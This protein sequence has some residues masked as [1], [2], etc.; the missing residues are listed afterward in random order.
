[1]VV[2]EVALAHHTLQASERRKLP[3]HDHASSPHE[4]QR[5][6]ARAFEASSRAQG[7]VLAVGVRLQHTTSGV[8]G[9][10][11]VCDSADSSSNLGCKKCVHGS[12]AG[13][14]ARRC[15]DEHGSLTDRS[16]NCPLRE[17]LGLG[18]SKVAR[19]GAMTEVLVPVLVR[20]VHSHGRHNCCANHTQD[21]PLNPP[22][23]PP[24][25]QH[26]HLKH[27]CLRDWAQPVAAV[28]LACECL[29]PSCCFA[30]LPPAMAQQPLF[31]SVDFSID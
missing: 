24:L 2:A 17:A 11:G 29:G 7:P 1:M 9:W 14:D 13:P 10:A 6:R 25:M 20:S 28:I 21:T 18:A 3:S 30:P 12:L 23:P 19:G 4:P 15:C 16:A 22:L 5:R 26:H 8:G 31:G 27:E